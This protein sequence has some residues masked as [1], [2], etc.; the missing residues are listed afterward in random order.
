MNGRAFFDLV[1]RMRD[2]QKQYYASRKQ[3]KGGDRVILNQSCAVEREV[4]AEIER[5]NKILASKQNKKNKHYGKT[6]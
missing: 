1:S 3:I 5:V 4:D 2:L 6:E